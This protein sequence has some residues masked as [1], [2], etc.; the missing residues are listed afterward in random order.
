[1][2]LGAGDSLPLPEAPSHTHNVGA[3]RPPR[4][5]EHVQVRPCTQQRE[6]LPSHTHVE[7]LCQLDWPPHFKELISCRPYSPTTPALS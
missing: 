7:Y 3:A 1:M 4:P 6:A 5:P 2:C